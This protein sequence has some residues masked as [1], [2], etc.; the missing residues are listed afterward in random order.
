VVQA[1][2]IKAQTPV[3]IKVIDK[4]KA[5]RDKIITQLMR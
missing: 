3:A 5:Q 4:E 1:V 2:H